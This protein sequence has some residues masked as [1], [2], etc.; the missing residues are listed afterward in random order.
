MNVSEAYTWKVSAGGGGGGGRENNPLLPS[1]I[2]GLIIGKSNCGKT[3]LLLNLL[4][5]P[6]WLDYGHLYVFGKSLHQK[7]Y[8]ILKAG[9]FQI[10]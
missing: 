5:R 10:S 2:R 4:L 6:D 8:K 7:E 9:F 3:T 1:N